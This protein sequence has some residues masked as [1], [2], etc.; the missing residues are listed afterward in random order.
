[1]E[2]TVQNIPFL[3]ITIALAVGILIGFHLPVKINL[4]FTLLFF[5]LATLIFANK[6]YR[7]NLTIP[8][9]IAIQIFFILLGIFITNL[10]NQK[11]VFHEKGEFIAV[12]LEK[13]LEKPN[14]FKSLIRIEAVHFHDSSIISDEKVLAYFEKDENVTD[15]KAGDIILFKNTPQFIRNNGNPFEFDYKSYL[16]QRKIYR[17]VY[18]SDN[19]WIK[20]KQTHNSPEIH[21]EKI[22][23][24]LLQIY[25]NQP[26]DEKEFEILSA[27]TL[28][29]KRELDPETKRIFS[30]SGAS[31]V[32][33]V[34]GL[35]V[36]IIFWVVSMLFGF[37]RRNRRGQILFVF[38]AIIILWS[39]SFIT[40]LS[41][42]VMRASFMFSVYIIGENINRRSNS[43]NLLAIS[44]FVLLLINPNNLFDVGFQL[45][46]AAVFGIVFLQPKLANLMVV[47]NK[48]LKFFWSLITVSVAAQLS[49]FPFTTYYFGQ[50]PVYFWITNTFIIPVVMV[51]IPLGILLLLFSKIYI[52]STFFAF[53]SNGIIKITYSLLTSIYNL[54]FS[55]LEISLNQIGLIIILFLLISISVYISNHKIFYLKTALIFFVLLLSANLI[56]DF[57][58]L[59]SNELIVYNTA[60][61][62]GIHLIHG[63]DNYLITD[64]K[65]KDDEIN[66]YPG[67]STRK[68]M[69][70]KPTIYL[71]ASDTLFKG[72]LIMKNKLIFFEGKTLL[73]NKELKVTQKMNLPDYIINPVNF[74][75]ESINDKRTTAIL[76]NKRFYSKNL[77]NNDQIHCTWLK[78]AFRKKW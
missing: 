4:L 3:R 58:I 13:P 49:T 53:L 25:R 68:K 18:L 62:N 50:F 1:M 73:F 45:S 47:K 35:H 27:L 40:G 46:Y 67:T 9:G 23:E 75:A 34:S 32:L 65:L 59:N 52:A 43:Y 31:H 19:N 57:S 36:G 64:E 7:Y 30:A 55:V 37:L 20:T 16:E 78:G 39:Y 28:G 51:L 22:R 54:P 15:L 48:I 70:L 44:A 63:K 77:D 11:P 41:P 42:S 74:K 8:F 66:Y 6:Y 5:V 24:N 72:D 38:L 71:T 12:V 60:K 61:N 2:K 33:A 10:Y 26:I 17:Q 29:Y 69:G 21:A 56:S 76:T 14:S